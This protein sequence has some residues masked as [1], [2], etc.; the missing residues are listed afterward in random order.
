[1]KLILFVGTF[2]FTAGL[3]SLAQS[4]NQIDIRVI[5]LGTGGPELSPQRSGYATLIEAG[6]QRLLFDAGRGV[7]QRIYESR[8]DPVSVAAVF[9]THLH[10]DHIEGLPGV[11]IT[12]WYL[13]GR[14]DALPIWGPE[15]TREMIAGMKA[16]YGHDIQNRS[17]RWNR[18]ADLE[19]AV[20]EISEGDIYLKDGVRV[21]AFPV[22]HGDGNPAF[23]YRISYRGKNVIL[24]GD[25]TYSGN[26]VKYGRNA[27][28][29]VHNVI[30][31]GQVYAVTSMQ[32][33]GPILAKLTTPE[34]AAR[35]FRETTPGMA[36]YSHIV[37]KALPGLS[38]DETIMQ[39]T[40]DAGYTGPLTMGYDR[41]MIEI[42]AD[43]SVRVLPPEGTANL[44]DVDFKASRGHA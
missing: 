39:R 7:L 17:N 28:L 1:M 31:L 9:L 15:G 16:M 38:G 14:T 8:I 34:Q 32:E 40:R 43:D 37:K 42:G 6:G 41:M 24:S 33:V 25:T 4:E 18:R 13:L 26:V 12:P 36:V 5:L 44:P 27:H 23:G 20:Q 11:W 35:I 21:T 19:P 29:I 30:A 2:L 3:P 10:S 22:S